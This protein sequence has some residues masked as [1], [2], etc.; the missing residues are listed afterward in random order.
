ML[1]VEFC[2]GHSVVQMLFALSKVVI[3]GKKPEQAG[4]FENRK[5]LI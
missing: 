4:W 3:T 2:V 5:G 1:A